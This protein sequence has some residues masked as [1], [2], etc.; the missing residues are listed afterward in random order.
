MQETFAQLPNLPTWAWASMILIAFIRPHIT[1]LAR[2]S[3][4]LRRNLGLRE[5]EVDPPLL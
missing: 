1:S 2:G 4:L 3:F 5:A